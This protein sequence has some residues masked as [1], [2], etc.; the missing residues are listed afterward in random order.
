[1]GL[2]AQDISG[3]ITYEG[4]VNEKF[5][6]SFIVALKKKD[7][8]MSIKK[9]VINAMRNAKKERFILNFKN[10]ESFYYHDP[11]LQEQNYMMGSRAGTTPYYI[12]NK[13]GMIIQMSNSL[14]NIN[15]QPV[16]WKITGKTKK[17]GKNSSGSSRTFN[18]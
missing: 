13:K 15:K 1:M 4:V 5:V 14:G 9:D 8:P 10:S 17:I 16:D 7:K 18:S 12:N 3:S 2:N 11:G 6:D